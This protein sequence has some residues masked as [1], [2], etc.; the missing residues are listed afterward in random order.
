MEP[1]G[2]SNPVSTCFWIVSYKLCSRWH[3]FPKDSLDCRTIAR[4]APRRVQ[5]LKMYS[6]LKEILPGYYINYIYIYIYISTEYRSKVDRQSIDCRPI[7][8][9][10]YRSMYRS[11]VPT[12]NMILIFFVLSWAWDREKILSVC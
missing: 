8:R 4:S 2:I 10:I 12:V 1:K 6:M 5:V 7:Y 9:L 11:R 3:V